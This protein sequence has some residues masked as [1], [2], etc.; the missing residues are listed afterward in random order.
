LLTALGSL[1]QPTERQRIGNQINAAM[2]FARADF[3]NVNANSVV[4]EIDPG[5]TFLRI[6]IFRWWEI[7]RM[8]ETSS[9]NVYL[10]GTFVGLIG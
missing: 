10:I 7:F 3:V 4:D 5:Q 9:S 1:P 2:I 6:N 8:I